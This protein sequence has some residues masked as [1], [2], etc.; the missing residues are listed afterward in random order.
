MQTV[1]S[2]LG[3]CSLSPTNDPCPRAALTRRKLNRD[4]MQVYDLAAVSLGS[5]NTSWVV[6]PL[7]A[8]FYAVLGALQIAADKYTAADAA[9]QAAWRRLNWG[10]VAL[11]TGCAAAYGR[12]TGVRLFCSQINRLV[13]VVASF[14]AMAA[15][16]HAEPQAFVPRC[17]HSCSESD[18]YVSRAGLWQ[19][20]CSSAPTCMPT[21]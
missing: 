4:F 10:Y 5:L 19:H 20:R 8:T 12:A 11:N 3:L 21:R 13:L 17:G 1:Q 16:V 18:G 7:L 9:T 15:H 14:V 6:P 2:V